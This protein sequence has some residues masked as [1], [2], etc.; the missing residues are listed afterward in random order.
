MESLGALDLSGNQ[1]TGCIPETL[2][3]KEKNE[4]NIS[5]TSLDLPYCGPAA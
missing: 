1:L 2:A 3:E 5:L 4:Y